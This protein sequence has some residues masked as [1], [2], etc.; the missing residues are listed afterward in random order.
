MQIDPEKTVL[1]I[2]GSSFLYR[3]YYSLRPLHTIEGKPVQAV[4]GF[5]RMMKKLIDTFKPHYVAL[6]WDSKGKTTRH[7]MYPDYKATR[8][9]PPSD[10]F[11]QKEYIIQ[12]ADLIGMKQVA[13]QGIEADDIMYSLGKECTER[14][15]NAMVVTLDKD[16]GQMLSDQ[17]VILDPFNYVI[18]DK[19]KFQ[20]KHGIPVAKL[21][22]YY[23]LL[24]DTSD[25][26]PGVRGIG[27]KTAADLVEQFASLEDLYEHLQQV[28][29]GRIRTA[30]EENQSECVFKP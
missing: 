22:F 24:G 29:T 7:A 14:G 18:I 28:K 6:V 13:H 16:M 4:Y 17:V 12:F 1:L 9:S 19:Q 5:C 26:I 27:Q 10:L 8:Q 15:Y 30:L 20:E 2:D 3:A 25:N 23:A 21:P 11:D